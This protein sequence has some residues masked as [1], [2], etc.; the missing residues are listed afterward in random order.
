MKVSIVCAYNTQVKMT[1][2]FLDRMKYTT[3][4]FVE[5]NN[6]IEMIL[7]NGGNKEDI[8]HPFITTLI[9]L[10]TN[11]GFSVTVNEGLKKVSPDSDY[12]FYVGNDSF[13]TYDGWLEDLINLQKDTGAGI[14]CPANDRPGLNAYK[15]LYQSETDEYYNVEFFPSIAYLITKK[16]F[17]KVGLW[18]TIFIRSGM[19]GDNDYC[20]RTRLVGETIIVSKN[21]LLK[22]LLS[23]EAPKLF[24]IDEDMRENH[25]RYIN[26]WHKGIPEARI[27]Y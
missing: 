8:V 20:A 15:H 1:K 18:D 17:D 4:K 27:W 10:D 14:V 22:H 7:V 3:K 5:D 23:Q 11:I 21:I 13:P 19:Y 24:N 6:E 12:I 2:D 16:C 25:Q 9:H 26:K